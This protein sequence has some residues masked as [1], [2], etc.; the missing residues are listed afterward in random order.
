MF[1]ILIYL[2]A[3]M[4]LTHPHAWWVTAGSLFPPSAPIFMPVRAALNDVPAWQ[5][6]AAVLLMLLVI[7]ALIRAGGR[8]YRGGVLHTGGRL[9]LRKAWHRA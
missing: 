2:G 7:L 9:G 1:L 5:V 4:G 8:V 3:L 6:G